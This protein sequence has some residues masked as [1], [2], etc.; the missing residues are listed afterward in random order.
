MKA[1]CARTSGWLVLIA[2]LVTAPGCSLFGKDDKVAADRMETAQVVSTASGEATVRIA[3]Y[4]VNIATKTS[5]GVPVAGLALKASLTKNF[6]VVIADDPAGNYYPDIKIAAVDPARNDPAMT[7]EKTVSVAMQV[8]PVGLLV[9]KYSAPPAHIEELIAEEG[10]AEKTFSGTLSQVLAKVASVAGT[11]GGLGRIFHFTEKVTNATGWPQALTV[12]ASSKILDADFDAVV[13]VVGDAV[14][15]FDKDVIEVRWGEDKQ[16]KGATPFYF[17]EI[18][19]VRSFASRITLTWGENPSD[20][21]SH[22]FTPPV[23]GTAYHVYFSSRGSQTVAPYADLDVDDTSS[24]G[25]E[26]IVV[27]QNAPGTYRYAV[28]H[29][30]GSATLASSGAHVKVIPRVG[31]PREIDVP[32]AASSARWW[33]VFDM[34]GATGVVTIVNRLQDA[35]PQAMVGEV[36]VVLNEPPMAASKR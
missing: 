33:H 19:I 15:I 12:A 35:P 27:A 4:D 21:D 30:S 17:E 11:A 3:D 1:N 34:D 20:L 36:P 9:H 28:H 5:A 2:V 26:N 24:F 18:E 14:G 16:G 8:E 13:A 29:F 22:L 25:P 23:E 32:T 10:I 6:V 7:G 31:A